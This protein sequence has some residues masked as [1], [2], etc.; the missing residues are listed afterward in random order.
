MGREA[1]GHR[2]EARDA[3]RTQLDLNAL[4]PFLANM[5]ENTAHDLR[6]QFA[7]QIFGR[8]LANSKDHG[9]FAWLPAKEVTESDD[10]SKPPV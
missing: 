4:E 7:K 1:S 8:P 3:K 2:K 6:E 10:K 9:G 5:D